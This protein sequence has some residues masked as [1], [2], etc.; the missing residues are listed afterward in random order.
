MV[1]EKPFD[2][3]SSCVRPVVQ[4]PDGFLFADVDLSAIENRVLGWMSNCHPILD[5]FKKGQDPY[6]AFATK[7][8]HK[9]YEELWHEYKVLGNSSKRTIAKPG[10]LGAGYRLGP[11]EQH[12][13]RKTGEMEA[14][15][16]LGYAWNMGVRQFTKED[17]ALSVDTF[18]RSYPEVVEFWYAIERAAK[19]CITTGREVDCWPVVLDMAGPFMRMRLPSGRCLHYFRPRIRDCKTPWGEVR[20]TITYEGLNDKKMW[21]LITTHGGKLTENPDQAISRDLLVHG[22]RIA[23]KEGLSVRV[24]VHDQIVALV[25]EKEADRQLRVL[26]ECMEDVPVWA[27][28]LPVGSSGFISKIFTKD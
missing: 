21:G 4:A 10:V 14:T 19:K 12:E 2:V 18:R 16:L 6:I 8:F 28:G 9:T 1:Y 7:L 5:V 11:G 20:P 24:H 26:K 25:P 17:S 23:K 13:N 27:K 3:L 22:M 15:G